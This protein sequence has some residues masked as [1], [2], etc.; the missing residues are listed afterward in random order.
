[1]IIYFRKA[2]YILPHHGR[3]VNLLRHRTA[4][5]RSKLTIKNRHIWSAKN[6]TDNLCDKILARSI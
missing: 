2:M 5:H 6:W 3:K 4:P 1:M